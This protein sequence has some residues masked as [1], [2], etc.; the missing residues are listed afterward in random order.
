[1]VSLKHTYFVVVFDHFKNSPELEVT[2]LNLLLLHGLVILKFGEDTA[3]L[4]E[5][6][7]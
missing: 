1:M 4:V 6:F 7:L 2:V 3:L 5:R